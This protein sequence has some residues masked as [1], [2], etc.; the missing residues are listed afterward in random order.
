MRTSFVYFCKFILFPLTRF[1]IAKT[2][3]EK[4][5]PEGS[6]IVAANHISGWD[7]CFI[8]NVLEKRAK[9]LRFIGA[10]DSIKTFFQSSLL[11]YFADTIVVN[12]KKV[13]RKALLRK[14]TECL[15]KNEIIVIYPEGDSNNKKEL[16]KGKTG[17]TE[18]I[19]KS[20]VPLLLIGT[21]KIKGSRIRFV[22]IREPLYF[23]EARKT[24]EKIKD[25]EEY[26]LFLRKT[27]DKIMQEISKLCGKPYPY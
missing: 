22:K 20:K 17:L 10:M 15:G 9:D 12:R 24:A 3:G 18:L 19:L 13:D 7:H 8:A 5:I 25:K 4:N 6:F 27:T 21:E 14:M 11:Y 1:F 2:Q 16:L 26:Y 23:S